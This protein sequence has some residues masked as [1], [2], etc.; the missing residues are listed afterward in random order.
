MYFITNKEGFVIAASSKFISK[1]GSR[2]I[3]SLSSILNDKLINFKEENNLSINGFDNSFRY[4]KSTLHSAFGELELYNLQENDIQTNIDDENIEYLKKIK[5]GAIV[6]ED[7]EYS[8]PD[9]PILKHE[10]ETDNEKDNILKEIEDIEVTN[11]TIKSD[12]NKIDEVDIKDKNDSYKESIAKIYPN[13]STIEIKEDTHSEKI[14]E[15]H[16]TE[17]EKLDTNSK[18]LELKIPE[19]PKEAIEES[20]QT[21]KIETKDQKEEKTSLVI[22]EYLSDQIDNNNKEDNL[23]DIKITKKSIVDSE[24]SE[25]NSEKKKKGLFNRNIFSWG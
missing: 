13:S 5:E 2:D 17:S 21:V 9:I 11:I 7:N 22:K 15:I 19:I 20:Y 18:E 24:E 4:T 10:K 16:N 6:K 23:S 12:L 14:E 1:L 25:L 3:C 8:I